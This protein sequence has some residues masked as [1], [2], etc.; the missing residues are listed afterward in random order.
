MTKLD[1]FEK[2]FLV[3]VGTRGKKQ[4][5]VY[6]QFKFKPSYLMEIFLNDYNIEYQMSDERFSGVS[7]VQSGQTSITSYR[8]PII[9]KNTTQMKY[10]YFYFTSN[11]IEKVLDYYNIKYEKGVKYND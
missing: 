5:P 8:I 11:I 10:H 2:I 7:L 6:A 3:Q 1:D 4:K 9:H